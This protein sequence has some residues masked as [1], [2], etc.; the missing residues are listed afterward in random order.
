MADKYE[1]LKPLTKEPKVF[2]VG[3]FDTETTGLDAEYVSGA[4][5]INGVFNEF[6]NPKKLVDYMLLPRFENVRWYAHNL[7][8][9]LGVLLEYLPKSHDITLLNGQVLNARFYPAKKRKHYFN[10]SLRLS[11]NISLA[12][13]GNAIN[14]PKLPTPSF[15]LPDGI[16]TEKWICER[17][18]KIECLECY[19]SRDVEIVYSYIEL[20]QN[21]I[22]RLGGELKN[23]LASTA[24]DLFR[25]KFLNE[26]Y[27]K[28]FAA[29]QEFARAAYYGGRVEPLVLG[30]S[31]NINVYDINS[32]YPYVMKNFEYPHPNFLIGVVGNTTLKEIMEF[33]GVSEVTIE[34]PKMSI[35][36]L[37]FRHNSHLYFVTGV[38][39]GIWT[40]I[41]LRKAIELGAKIKIIHN[42][43]YSTKTCRPFINYV[44]TL[45]NLRLDY[46]TQNDPR[47]HVIKILLNSL[48]GKFGQRD[49]AGLEKLLPLDVYE[50]DDNKAGYDF[51]TLNDIVYARKSVSFKESPI[52]QNTLFASYITAYARLVLLDY[53]LENPDAVIY[54]DTDSIFTKEKLQTGKGLGEMKLEYE[55]IDVEVFG[56]KA[57]Q[58]FKDDTIIATKVRGIPLVEQ[59][60]YLNSHEATYLKSL[61]FLEANKRGLKPSSWV[62]ITKHLNEL[63]PKRFYLTSS[64]VHQ[65]NQHSRAFSLEELLAH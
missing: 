38:V 19:L 4:T 36:V 62:E 51:V 39:H 54:C 58:M 57:Y 17:H 10:D 49:D 52:Y 42:S 18:N 11:A 65:L 28:P 59:I 7:T 23:T 5:Y 64:E 1:I 60:K 16:E 31:E 25:R 12:R 43:L 40:H 15:L 24:M 61:G 14:L 35:P 30:F 45:Y 34:I 46:K 26:E 22:N 37:P 56:C 21:E 29:R 55:G 6:K 20:F 44:D 41:E 50:N 63:I 53:M 2:T 8:Y 3:S 47:E 9:D 13:I 48:Y 27:F 32:L 33:E